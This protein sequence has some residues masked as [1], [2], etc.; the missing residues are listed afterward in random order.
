[1]RIIAGEWR[2]R[3]LAA[4]KGTDTRPTT[5]RVRESLMSALASERGGFEDAV[6]LDAFAGSG[7]LGLEALSRGASCAHFFEKDSAALRALC[8]NFEKLGLAAGG[9]SRG[10]RNARRG[11]FAAEGAKTG[12]QR[13]RL[14]REDV[15]KRPPTFVRPSFD[16][17]FFD[18]PYAYDACEVLG[19]VRALEE[20]GALADDAVVCYEHDKRQDFSE[21]ALAEELVRLQLTVVSRKVYG[22]TVIEI[23]RRRLDD[24]DGAGEEAR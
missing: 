13:A 21:G 1:M 15:L 11:G 16:L 10:G 3:P 22:G 8:A 19:V 7:A 9:P 5:D 18:P 24:V 23:M 20:A 4:P 2:G 17:V 14:H 12:A 6:V